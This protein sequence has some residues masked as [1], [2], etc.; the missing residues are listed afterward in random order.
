M[1]KPCTHDDVAAHRLRIDRLCLKAER[2]DS[3]DVWLTVLPI[4]QEELLQSP[5]DAQMRANLARAHL[6]LG[7]P[8]EAVRRAESALM[9]DNDMLLG[10]TLSMLLAR[11][12]TD[13]GEFDLAVKHAACALASRPGDTDAL[14]ILVRAFISMKEFRRGEQ[15]LGILAQVNAERAGNVAQ[16]LAAGLGCLLAE[17][18]RWLSLAAGWV[19]SSPVL[20][21]KELAEVCLA[22]QREVEARDWLQKAFSHGEG[23]CDV[24]LAHK[25]AQLHVREGCIDQAL[26][27]YRIAINANAQGFIL[28]RCYGQLLLG[29]GKVAAAVDS[30]QRAARL[31]PLVESACVYVELA[32]LHQSMGNFTSAKESFDAALEKNPQNDAAWRGLLIVSTA[33]EDIQERVRALRNLSRLEPNHVEWREQL[34]AVT[35]EIARRSLP[36]DVISAPFRERNLQQS[37]APAVSGFAQLGGDQ[38]S[39]KREDKVDPAT[40]A[41][42]DG[43]R[44]SGDCAETEPQKLTADTAELSSSCRWREEFCEGQAV[45]VYSKSAS[46]WIEA[47]VISLRPNIV[48]VKYLLDDSWCEKSL[49]RSSDSLR[50]KMQGSD[51]GQNNVAN[52]KLA[53]GSGDG[54]PGDKGST[55]ETAVGRQHWSPEEVKAQPLLS[56]D[57][58]PA[59]RSASKTGSLSS[60]VQASEA[61]PPAEP[62]VASLPDPAVGAKTALSAAGEEPP[63]Q[64][65]HGDASAALPSA[66]SGAAGRSTPVTQAAEDRV[67]SPLAFLLDVRDLRFDRVLGTGAFGS[68]YCGT[69]Q[70]ATVAIKKMHPI[71]GAVTPE[72]IEEFRKE[73]V[74]L[75]A[76]RHPRLVAF[77]GAAFSSPHLCIVTEF[78]PNGSLYE[79]LH[80]KKETL[81]IREQISIVCQIAEGVAFLHSQSPPFV[82]RDLKSMNVVLDFVLNIKLCDFGLTQ[83]ME[84]THISRRDN[85]AGSPRYMA[86]ELFDCRGKITEKV[87]V[88][89]LGCLALEVLS[90]RMPHEECTNIQQVMTK[91]LVVCQSPFKDLAGVPA[92]IRSIAE[93]CLVFQPQQRLDAA[94]FLDELRAVRQ[95]LTGAT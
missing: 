53:G 23:T 66:P 62:N 1:F 78:V 82:H 89:A 67:P 73:V 92:E 50:P 47:N 30:L 56:S 64:I 42:R 48:R 3:R 13:A 90:G 93:R 95:S 61:M 80:Q 51:G 14:E 24:D 38:T 85:E 65:E 84:K 63:E 8:V 6:A 39:R 21:L 25:L 27:T 94:G 37:V 40:V 4:L 16:S 83:S 10:Y 52:P 34:A 43:A 70:G 76:L 57:S 33:R 18:H 9:V 87:D 91:T 2:E 81:Y 71:D 72:Q 46:R 49:L 45:E 35:S 19:K 32:D 5:G 31:A 79:L 58:T 54:P 12:Y 28:H 69:F 36:G 44:C 26:D 22:L 7:D 15:T 20:L 41:A 77:I 59:A 60:S 74:N 11:N 88:W 55:Q 86:P 75:Q 29:E 17:R 68:V